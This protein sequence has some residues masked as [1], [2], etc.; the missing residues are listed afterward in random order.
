[1]LQ[2]RWTISTSYCKLP[3]YY[4]IIKLFKVL[5]HFIEHFFHNRGKR[6][7]VESY[8]S[9]AAKVNVFV[10]VLSLPLVRQ[11]DSLISFQ[12]R[13]WHLNFFL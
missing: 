1:M 12:G 2:D 13:V 9:F 8:A 6:Q 5:T 11:A 4:W 7:R 10:P 3:R